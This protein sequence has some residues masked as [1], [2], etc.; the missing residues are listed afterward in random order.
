MRWPGQYIAL[1][2][3]TGTEREA[4]GGAAPMNFVRTAA[5]QQ[6]QNTAGEST[7][8]HTVPFVYNPVAAHPHSQPLSIV[9]AEPQAWH[10]ARLLI[11]LLL[12]VTVALSVGFFLQRITFRSR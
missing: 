1:V 2:T 8:T 12:D 5:A 9:S 7:P 3:E 11:G 10:M 6:A 4:P